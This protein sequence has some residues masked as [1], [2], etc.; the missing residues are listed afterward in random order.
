MNKKRKKSVRYYKI[1]GADLPFWSFVASAHQRFNPN[2]VPCGK[3]ITAKGTKRGDLCI[4]SQTPVIHF[5]DNA[6]DAMLWLSIFR[7]HNFAIYEITPLTPVIKQKCT[8]VYELDQCGATTIRI[9][10]IV[11]TDTMFRRALSEYGKKRKQ[12]Q[13]TYPHL[14]YTKIINALRQHT[15]PTI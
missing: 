2:L 1:I 12:I 6:F 5:T 8:D 9:E 7:T 15:I 3:T 4:Q 11:S 10:H 13:I 14:A